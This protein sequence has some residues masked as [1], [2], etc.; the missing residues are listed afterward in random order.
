MQLALNHHILINAHPTAVGHSHGK[1]LDG[2]SID[3][4]LSVL[5]LYCAL[6]LAVGGVV[7]EQ[8]HLDKCRH[9]YNDDTSDHLYT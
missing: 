1:D 7:L 4:Q 6:E 5:S 8:V 9:S 2:I 3:D